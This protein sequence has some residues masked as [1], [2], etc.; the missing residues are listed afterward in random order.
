MPKLDFNV[1]RSVWLAPM[2]GATDYAYRCIAKDE[3]CDVTVTEMVSTKALHYKDE[4]SFRLMEA[5][6]EKGVKG[7]QIFGSDPDIF[8][9]VTKLY[10]NDTV[11]D[12]IDINMGCPAPKIVKNGDGSALMT[13]V[14]IAQRLVDAVKTVSTKPV[15]VKMRI[16]FEDINGVSF[17]KALANAGADLITVHGRTRTQMYTGEANWDEIARI[18]DAVDVPLIGNG[19]IFTL[20]DAAKRL[21]QGVCDGIMIGRGAQGRPWLFKQIK[22]AMAGDMVSDTPSYEARVDYI[23]RHIALML[24]IKPE[25]IVVLEMRKHV[26]WYLKGVSGT[27]KLKAEINRTKSVEQIIQLLET[28]TF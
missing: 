4:K 16:G 5:R 10:L 7:I 17:A 2:A 23:K 12:F 26:A 8:K 11:Y 3:G 19:D 13:R 25:F 15:T 28:W 20:F 27:Q 22:E 18:R 21:D 24:K 6:D 1:T 9:S 14:D